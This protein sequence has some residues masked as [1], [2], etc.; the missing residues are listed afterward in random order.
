MTGLRGRRPLVKLPS[1]EIMRRIRLGELRRLFADRYRGSVLPDDDAGRDD[2][3]E[4]LLPISLGPHEAVKR[5]R[6]EIWGP[7]ERMRREIERWAP[8]M[9]E[10]EAQEVIDEINLTPE[11]QRRPMARTLGERLQLPY[12][13]RARLQIQ[14]IGPHD[15]TGAAMELIRKQKKRQRDRRRRISQGA[16]TR[17]AYLAKHATSKQ[18]PWIALNISRRTYYHRIKQERANCTG[19]RQV[20][21]TKTGL[22][23]VQ[24]EKKGSKASECGRVSTPT[25]AGQTETCAEFLTADEAAWLVDSICPLSLEAAA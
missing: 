21:L 7:I 23:L 16:E 13:E 1:D 9:S 18:Q 25:P 20:N 24:K 19:P 11:W 6:V 22:A 12:T 5:S 14:T 17:A 3:R 2:L 15:M 4:L 10:D 8:W